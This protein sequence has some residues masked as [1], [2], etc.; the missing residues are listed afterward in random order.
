NEDGGW[1]FHIDGHSTMF[2]SAFNY[3]ALRL[4]GEGPD[5]GEDNAVARGRQWILNHGVYEWDGCNPTP[6]ELWL[7][8]K[9][10]PMHPGA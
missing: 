3:I 8:P 4:L 1:G 10:L 2:G 7:L 9:F 6:P 5:D